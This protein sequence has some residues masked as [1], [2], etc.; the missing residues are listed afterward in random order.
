MLHEVQIFNV[1]A[2]Q[3]KCY[4][5]NPILVFWR[6]KN[7]TCVDDGEDFNW[8]NDKQ[9]LQIEFVVFEMSVE[10]RKSVDANAGCKWGRS[11]LQHFCLSIF[12]WVYSLKRVLCGF[13]FGVDVRYGEIN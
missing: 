9:Q 5:S 4:E 6:F 2:N 7:F 3:M 10:S 12:V 1:L 11:L 13:V 8:T